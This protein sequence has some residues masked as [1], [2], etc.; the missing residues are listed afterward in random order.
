MST[1]FDPVRVARP[2]VIK[3]A[4]APRKAPAHLKGWR[5]AVILPDPQ[6]GFRSLPEGLDPFHDERALSVAL[7]VLAAVASETVVDEIVN[8]GDFLDLPAHSKYEQ[9]ANFQSTT[10]AAID[11]GHRF[12]A[13]QRATSP[14]SRIY[15][16]EGNHDKRISDRIA[17]FN[18]QSQGLRRADMPE[19]WPQMSA[20]MLLRLNEK[21]LNVEYVSGYPA[22]KVWL[23]DWIKCV[24][25]TIVRS[26]GSTASAY[27]RSER[28][29]TLFGHIHRLEAH[30]T[31][32]QDR[33]GPV[34]LFAATP[35]CLCR[36]DGTVPSVRGGVDLH[37]RPIKS[38]EDWQ[39]GLCVLR[40]RLDEP[41]YALDLVHIQDGWTMYGGQEFKAA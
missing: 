18:L 13:R 37:G 17:L 12:L 25:G 8:L 4:K 11:E 41:R 9:H 15:L 31:T 38:Y 6:F 7:Q 36:V 40:Y 39:Q 27:S 2:T 30:H 20:P 29:S 24:H 32:Q 19:D 34:R 26:S 5:T 23:N 10:Q 16:L 22:S 1:L 21:H 28:T 14:H 33:Y 35:G 3:A